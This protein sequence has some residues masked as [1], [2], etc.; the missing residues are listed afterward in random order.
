MLLDVLSVQQVVL[1]QLVLLTQIPE[2][3]KL[4]TVFVNLVSMKLALLFAQ[5]AQLNA[6]LVKQLPQSAPAVIPITSSL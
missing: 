1:V 3:Q 6:R 2:K 4:K 5:H